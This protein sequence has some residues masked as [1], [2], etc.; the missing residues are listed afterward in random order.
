MILLGWPG[1]YCMWLYGSG[2]DDRGHGNPGGVCLDP[3]PGR[4]GHGGGLSELDE[5]FFRE[6][7]ELSCSKVLVLMG[8]YNDVNDLLEGQQ[9]GTRDLGNCWSPLMTTSWYKWL[10]CQQGDLQWSLPTAATL[11]WSLL[12]VLEWKEQINTTGSVK[13]RKTY[14]HAKGI[15]AA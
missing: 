14:S 12:K 10:R 6:L 4:E 7:E 13:R 11:L 1:K 3:S 9:Q 8:D 2:R 15:E 5:A